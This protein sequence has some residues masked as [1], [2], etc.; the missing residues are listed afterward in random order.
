MTLISSKQWRKEACRTCHL[1]S[2][3]TVVLGSIGAS[4]Q[5]LA[6]T[7]H[8]QHELDICASQGGGTNQWYQGC[9]SCRGHCRVTGHRSCL[10][11]IQTW[12]SNP[13]DTSVSYL[14]SH[15]W[16][17]SCFSRVR[18]FATLWTVACQAPLS[19]GFSRQ[20]YWSG[21][22]RL[23]PGD[24]PNPRIEPMSHYVSCIAGVFF[25]TSGTWEAREIHTAFN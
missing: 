23:L 9:L 2:M 1:A 12:F 22:P 17:L 19:M 24:R 4:L 16:V 3:A 15:A 6:S 14:C 20:E 13:L 10:L 25:I 5:F 11:S 21:L 8:H 18:L 7:E